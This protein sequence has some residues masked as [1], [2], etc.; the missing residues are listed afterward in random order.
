VAIVSKPVG[1]RGDIEASGAWANGKWVV[2]QR[3]LLN[4][5]HDDEV[6]GQPP[7]WTCAL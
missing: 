1:S 5:G 6:D 2:V 4:T 3:R 7:P